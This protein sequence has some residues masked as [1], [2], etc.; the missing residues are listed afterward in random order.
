M[1]LRM[2][3]RGPTK[4]QSLAVL[5]A[6]L[7]ARQDKQS[8]VGVPVRDILAQIAL[9]GDQALLHYT[10]KFDHLHY[11][12]ARNLRI[13]AKDIEKARAAC[14]PELLAALELAAERIADYHRRQLPE[15]HRYTD[16][17]GLTLGWRYT[18]LDA[19]GLYVPGGRAAYP[20]SVLMNAIPAKVAG[21]GRLVVTVPTPEGVTNDAVLAAA[22][23]AGVDE[24]YRVGGAQAVGALAYGTQ[25]IAP[26]DKIVG[27][28]NAWVA[29]A[30]RQV[31]GQVG[32]D[33]IAGPS[34]ILVV[35]DG[36]ND[37]F[38]IAADLM[39]QA[40]HDHLAQSILITDDAAFA[41]AVVQAVEETLKRLP[42]EAIARE[43]WSQWGAVLLVESIDSAIDV[44]DLIA[45]EHLEL[46][47][48]EPE[49]LATRVRHAG[50]IFLGRHT[51]EALGDY[52]AGPSHVLPTSRTARFSSG[53]G[54]FDFLKRTSLLGCPET[55]FAPLAE[56]AAILADAEGLHAHALSLR[57]R[58]AAGKNA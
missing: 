26:V 55:S 48:A 34:E 5:R 9:R 29:E 44:I 2:D 14:A 57:L 36:A 40:E 15:N 58:I 43:A 17:Q 10:D 23:I 49:A 41:D 3:F 54:V 35:A 31:F 45:P 20:S 21:V 53:L 33:M 19:V 46:C 52:L 11:T 18:P 56:A 28:G 24:V 7:Q 30:K 13:T 16:A 12:D 51:P 39:S 42:R 25:T 50:A 32:I 4:P 37:P 47:V 38:W 8:D 1:T 6:W 27:P 22:G